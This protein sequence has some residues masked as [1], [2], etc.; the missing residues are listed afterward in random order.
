MGNKNTGKLEVLWLISAED[1]TP[2]LPR[3]RAP[4]W[5]RLCVSTLTQLSDIWICLGSSIRQP[6][7]LVAFFL[8][9]VVI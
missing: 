7:L 9:T 1:V 4:A 8:V 5:L 6:S 2:S 3:V